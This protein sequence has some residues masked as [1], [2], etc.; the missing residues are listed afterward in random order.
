M[1]LLSTLLLLAIAAL[2]AA[3][4][5]AALAAAAV[6]AAVGHSVRGAFRGSEVR[7]GRDAHVERLRQRVLAE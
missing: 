7:W 3:A 6:A 4:I 5:T 1:L 2:A